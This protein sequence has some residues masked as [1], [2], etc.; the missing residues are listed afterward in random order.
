MNIGLIILVLFI[1]YFIGWWHYGHTIENNKE[2]ERQLK[3]N[4]KNEKYDNLL[5]E[6][7]DKNKQSLGKYKKYDTQIIFESILKH[8]S[9]NNDMWDRRGDNI[10]YLNNISVQELKKLVSES[11]DA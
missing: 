2:E 8:E 5:F 9:Q 11:F 6:V 10:E 7:I 4:K 3:Q 1:G